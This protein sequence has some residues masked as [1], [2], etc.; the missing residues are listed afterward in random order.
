MTSHYHERRLLGPE[1]TDHSGHGS[2]APKNANIGQPS[3]NAILNAEDDVLKKFIEY[4]GATELDLAR[5]ILHRR[6]HKLSEAEREIR[7]HER[8]ATGRESERDWRA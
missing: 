6:C 8:V 1:R 7:E 2:A 3:R 5:D 4:T